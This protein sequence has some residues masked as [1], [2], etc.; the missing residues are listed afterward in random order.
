VEWGGNTPAQL[1]VTPFAGKCCP[2]S[3]DSS[4][5]L[6]AD[7][8]AHGRAVNADQ[9]CAPAERQARGHQD[10]TSRLLADTVIP[11]VITPDRPTDRRHGTAD[12]ELATEV[13]FGNAGPSPAPSKFGTQRFSTFSPFWNSAWQVILWTA[14]S[15]HDRHNWNM[16]SKRL[17]CPITRC[18]NCFS[19]Q[20]D[21]WQTECH[22]HLHRTV[23]SIT[24]P[25][26][27]GY[28][29]CM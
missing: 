3:L 6:L 29:K 5:V 22:W 28:C 7:F 15:S 27:Y 14:L 25:L 18:D 19:R 1:T 8:P 2:V 17:G 4:S 12:T 21:C 26:F 10:K 11:H 24:L 23:S 20:D 16:R 13:L 9:Y